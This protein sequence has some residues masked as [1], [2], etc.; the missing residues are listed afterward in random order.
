MTKTPYKKDLIITDKHGYMKTTIIILVIA[1]FIGNIL[2]MFLGTESYCR[3]AMFGGI[4]SV[5]AICI[6]E[7]I[8]DMQQ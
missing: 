2:W 5:P 6:K 1:I 4:N 3:F 7:A 8:K